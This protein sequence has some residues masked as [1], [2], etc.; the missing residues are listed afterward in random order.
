MGE[1]RPTWQDYNEAQRH[2]PVRPLVARL[3]E[4]AGPGGGRPA[5]DLGCGGGVETRALVAQGW[6]VTAVDTDPTMPARLADLVASGDVRTVVGDVRELDLGQFALVHSSLTLP[7]VPRADFGFAWER[8]R[9]SLLPGGWLGVDLFGVR[10]D[11]SGTAELSFHPRA[12]IDQLLAG[13]DVLEVVEEERDGPAFGGDTK[14]WHVFHCLARRP[15]E[16]GR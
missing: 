2:R 13:L 3:L 4:H 11:W 12:G 10:D 9:R 16:A 6:H 14:H 1:G 15:A 8:V 7:F 5:L